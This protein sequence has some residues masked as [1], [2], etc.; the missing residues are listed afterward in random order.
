[1]SEELK[2]DLSNY[3]HKVFEKPSN[4]VDNAIFKIIDG[5]LSILLIKRKNPPFRDMWAL[6]GGF[7]DVDV[8][9]NPDP[10]LE[11]AALRELKEETSVENIQIKQFRTYGDINRDPRMRV[12]SIV[13]YAIIPSNMEYKVK[14]ND[15]AKEYMWA[16]IKDLP[17]M[18]FDHAIIINDILNT[19]K[20]EIQYTDLAFTFIPK[21]FSIDDIFTI[22]NLILEKDFNKN[23]VECHDFITKLVSH[24]V[25]DI[26]DNGLTFKKVKDVFL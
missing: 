26:T 25:I 12:V 9:K 21:V 8:N 5:K 13:Y 15:D 10:S 24:F 6:P 11:F 1:M 17:P 18:A 19:F 3:N 16:N 20:K 7:L 23:A 22:F 4:T 14:A 2:D